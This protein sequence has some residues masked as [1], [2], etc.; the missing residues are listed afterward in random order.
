ML[1]LVLV[2]MVLL[3]MMVLLPVV[4]LLVQGVRE[5]GCARQAL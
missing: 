1:M 5:R 2:H 3:H 4:V